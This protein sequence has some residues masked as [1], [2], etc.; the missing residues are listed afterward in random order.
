[1]GEIV[2]PADS[3]QPLRRRIV[4]ALL[5]ASGAVVFIAERD[6]RSRPAAEI[7]GPKLAWRVGCTNALVAFAYLRWGRRSR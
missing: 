2:N 6:L 3:G 1:M 5:V 7:R 4:A